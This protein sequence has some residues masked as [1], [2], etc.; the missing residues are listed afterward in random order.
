MPKPVYNHKPL[1]ILLDKEY[2]KLSQRHYASTPKRGEIPVG[3]G[4]WMDSFFRMEAIRG[5]LSALRSGNS[6]TKAIE[7]GKA[8]SEISVQIWNKRREWQV[9]RW[10]KTA[11]PYLEMLVYR[12]RKVSNAK[13]K[14]T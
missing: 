10:P 11:H 9:H 7:D 13:T 2:D 5:C 1:M 8:V 6:L 3:G 12:L 4:D 14:K